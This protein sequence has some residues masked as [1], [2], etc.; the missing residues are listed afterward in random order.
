[1]KKFDDL[2]IEYQLLLVFFLFS[3][4]MITVLLVAWYTG[5]GENWAEMGVCNQ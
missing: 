1:M 3:A 5:W 4:L 2:K